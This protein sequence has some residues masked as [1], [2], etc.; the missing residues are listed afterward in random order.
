MGPPG[1]RCERLNLGGT[2]E[3]AGEILLVLL[4]AGA[5]MAH[6]Q[7]GGVGLRQ[8][9]IEHHVG[10]GAVQVTLGDL[11]G[12]FDMLG[13]YDQ[14]FPGGKGEVVEGVGVTGQVDL[15]GQVLVR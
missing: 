4:G 1:T 9:D 8:L 3:L 10:E 12:V 2:R 14:L 15:G 5:G 7:L 11:G 6:L 13:G